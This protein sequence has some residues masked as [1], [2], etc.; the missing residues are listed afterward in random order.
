[1]AAWG[2]T[3]T[4]PLVTQV[5]QIIEAPGNIGVPVPGSE[6]KLVPNGWKLEIRVKGPQLTPGY[7]R[8][9]ERFR[10]LLDEEG[11]YSAGDAVRLADPDDPSRGLV[12]DGRAS[13]DFKLTTGTWVHVGALRVKLIGALAPLVQDAVIA[14]HD[15][16]A[17][18]ALLFPD[19][20]ACCKAIGADPGVPRQ[21]LVRDER[22]C[23]QIAAALRAHNQEEHGGS[24]R[25]VVSA[26]LLAE[27][28]SI[29]A[30]EITDKGYINQRAVLDRRVALVEKLFAPEAEGVIRI[31]VT[32]G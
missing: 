25:A 6:V 16:D 28:P 4:S 3:E 7:F 20:A 22:L 8:D 26:L 11:F 27:P 18:G 23:A 30:G 32:S 10:A 2:A 12:F 9:E 21:D 5:H 29:D 14:G 13:E 31:E 17:V 15:R 24:S 1:V 19:F